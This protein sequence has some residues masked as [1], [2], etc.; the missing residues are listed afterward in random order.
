MPGE[1]GNDRAVRSWGVAYCD[2][3]LC[4]AAL[5]VLASCSGDSGKKADSGGEKVYA[6][7]NDARLTETG[8]RALVPSDFYSTLTPEHKKEIVQEWINNELLYQEAIRQKIDG[9][10][11]IA[12]IIENSTRT[13]VSNELLERNLNS[14]KAP[15]DKQLQAFFEAHKKNFILP[16]REYKI[17]FASFE[18]RRD[19]E[20]FWRKV[21]SRSGFSELAA[22]M[23][24]DPS[25]RQGGDLGSVSE[26]M[27]EPEVWT[28]IAETVKKFGLV[29][30]SD[31]FKIASGY[32]CV[33]VDEMYEAG[34]VKS[35]ES[36]RDQV[37]DMYMV[38]K[39]EEA[40]KEL[41][42]KLTSSAKVTL[43]F[44]NGK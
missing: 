19:A 28:A 18:N 3:V 30:I 5:V 43:S 26:E 12:R 33:I 2:T 15:D 27:V 42:K 21:K 13:L 25:A 40:R 22:D 29:K 23:S 8:L 10:P 41:I 9:D 24:K 17:R 6:S 37:R 34:S 16:D 44:E 31:P 32:A 38:E 7:V 4:I 14:V 20:D 1:N 36:V 39:R 11:E 35:F